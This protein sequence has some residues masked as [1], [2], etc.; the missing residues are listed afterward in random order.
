MIEVP[1]LATDMIAVSSNRSFATAFQRLQIRELGQLSP[2]QSRRHKTRISSAC[3][4][5]AKLFL[6]TAALLLLLDLETGQVCA[7]VD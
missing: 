7:R 4:I 2:E 6:A 5:G 1:L 3:Q